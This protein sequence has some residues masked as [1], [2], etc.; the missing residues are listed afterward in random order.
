MWFGEV[1]F[2]VSFR[3]TLLAFWQSYDCLSASDA[4]RKVW[5]DKL[6]NQNQ[7]YFIR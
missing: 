7:E 4:T 2:P 5:V 6:L 1:V 3:V